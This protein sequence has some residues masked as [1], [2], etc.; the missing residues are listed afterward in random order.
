MSGGTG[1]P[2]PARL[3]AIVA[4]CALWGSSF[5]FG[6][7]ALRELAVSHLVL[8]RFVL[9]SAVL[10]PAALARG[11]L[12]RRADLPLYAVAGTLGVPV[13][14]LLQ[15]EGLART[16][17]ASA[18]LIVGTGA[19]LLAIA[20]AAF[21]RDRLDRGGWAAVGLSTLGVAVLMGVPGAGR[22]PL[23]DLLVF[24]S[25]VATTGYVLL[26][27]R[28]LTRQGALV[29]TAWSLAAGT[30]VLAPVAWVWDGAPAAGGL[31][32]AAWGSVLALGLVCTATTYGLWN[33]GLARVPASRAGVYLNLEPVV[34]VALG[35]AL[36]GEPLSGATA[37]GGLLVLAAAV[38]VSLPA[39][40]AAAPAP[41]APL[42]AREP[43]PPREAR[44]A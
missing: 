21:Q 17:V 2:A 20:A 33:W 35:V 36:L 10:V 39:R 13:T 27:V 44:A 25:M 22:S 37:A 41:A 12:P 34:G 14:F 4:A 24:L 18:S 6:K 38:R 29:A 23:G 9:A 8:A 43:A 30:A 26:S 32:P 7:I 31:S 1:R 42:P 16:T 5:L 40:A 11:G 19:P 15:F 3:A 28:L